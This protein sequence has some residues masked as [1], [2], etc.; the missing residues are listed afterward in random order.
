[1]KTQFTV[2]TTLSF[3]LIT[4]L[5]AWAAPWEGHNKSEIVRPRILVYDQVGIKPGTLDGAKAVTGEIFRKAG[6]ELEWMDCSKSSTANKS[7]CGQPL[8]FNEIVLLII[9]RPKERSSGS[10][11]STGGHAVRTAP[12]RGNGMI[13]I[14]FERT[15]Q[16]AEHGITFYHVKID[17]AQSIVLGHLIAH[18][19]GHVLLSNGDHS[20]SGIMKEWLLQREWMLAVSGHLQFTREQAEMIRQGVRARSW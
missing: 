14:F 17:K 19:I 7:V 16:I 6:V 2:W 15:E 5:P 8:T 9:R 13:S 4:G 1:M 20:R 18:E 11:S 12:E 3:L 10:G